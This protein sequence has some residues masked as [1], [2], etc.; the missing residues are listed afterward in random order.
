MR[1][2][3]GSASRSLVPPRLVLAN[4]G[5]ELV[6]LSRSQNLPD[7]VVRV[8]PQ[9]LKLRVHLPAQLAVFVA[10]IL[11]NLGELLD[12]RAREAQFLLKVT[13]HTFLGKAT[14]PAAGVP[15]VI[16]HA[17]PANNDAQHERQNEIEVDAALHF[18]V[19]SLPSPALGTTA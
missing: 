16:E 7:P 14:A 5:V 18:D 11:D 12:L 15:A 19:S 8:F 9:R 3:L 13:H 1:E 2:T 10:R 6:E 4:Q 17:G